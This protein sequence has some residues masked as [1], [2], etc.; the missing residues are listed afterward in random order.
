MIAT[1]TDSNTETAKRHRRNFR[2]GTNSIKADYATPETTPETKGSETT[3][4][5]GSK[6]IQEREQPT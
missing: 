5:Y 2:N 1:H 4:R 3:Y 6:R